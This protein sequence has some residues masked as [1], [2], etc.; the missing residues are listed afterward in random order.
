MVTFLVVKTRMG[1]VSL[2]KNV[3]TRQHTFQLSPNFVRNAYTY[4]A[5]ISHFS[6]DS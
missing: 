6:D 2:N 4:S 3:G 1:S 5:S